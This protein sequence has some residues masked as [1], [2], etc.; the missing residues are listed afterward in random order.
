MGIWGFQIGLLAL[1]ASTV[2]A[3]LGVAIGVVAI[4]VSRKRNMTNDQSSLFVGIGVSALIIAL[5]GMQFFQ[6][7]RSAA[8]DR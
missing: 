5:M 6:A 4:F 1:A 2:L 3:V 8:P 7:H